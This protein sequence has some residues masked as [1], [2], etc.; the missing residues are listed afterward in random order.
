MVGWC[1]WC[2]PEHC[3]CN[4]VN[5][6]PW[7]AISDPASSHEGHI[8]PPALHP[9]IPFLSLISLSLPDALI[10]VSLY[11]SIFYISTFTFCFPYYNSSFPTSH[12]TNTPPIQFILL[13]V[14][15]SL[16]HED[17][18]IIIIKSNKNCSKTSSI[19]SNVRGDGAQKNIYTH[20]YTQT[21]THILH[22]LRVYFAIK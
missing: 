3:S 4:R 16:L 13:Y 19:N 15:S 2:F 11:N 12:L 7:W 20:T 8:S 14:F 18:N 17:R 6:A 21:H 1:H 5:L 22:S 10:D 9:T